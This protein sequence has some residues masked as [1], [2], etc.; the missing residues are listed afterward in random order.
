MCTVWL[1]HSKWLSERRNESV[2]NF[3]L[4]LNIPPWKLFMWFRRLQLWATSDWHFITTMHLLMHHIL[5]RFLVK[6]QITQMTQ[7]H[8]SP[9]LVPC[10][11]WICPKLKLPLRTRDFRPFM[12]FRKI[13]Q[14]ADDYGEN[15]VRPQ[16]AYFEGDWG[17][18]VLCTMFL[19]STIFFNKCLYFL[20]YVTEY[21]LER[22]HT[23]CQTGRLNKRGL[24]KIHI[25]TRE[26]RKE[27]WGFC[28]LLTGKMKHSGECYIHYNILLSRVIVSI[29][30][31]PCWLHYWYPQL[32]DPF[33]KKVSH[34]LQV[35]N[36]F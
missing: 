35:P 33:V 26:S 25:N 8:Y 5:Q 36:A 23:I 4:S 3:A 34:L 11:F 13:Q 24:N 22:T 30:N 16:S 10:I 2:S 29:K 32:V 15:C 20:Y 7:P 14:A 27:L 12:R 17:I 28:S 19:V 21:H 18:I 31:G 9:D 1:S 6:H